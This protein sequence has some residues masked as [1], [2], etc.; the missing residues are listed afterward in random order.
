MKRFC[1]SLALLCAFAAAF[2]GQLCTIDP[3]RPGASTGLYVVG[4]KLLDVAGDEFRIRGFNRVHHDQNTAGMGHM[5]ANAVR[6][7]IDFA[8]PP[9]SSWA[10]V[11]SIAVANGLMPIVGNWTGTCKSDPAVLVTI[12]DAWVAQAPTWTKLNDIGV[13]NIANEFG[14]GNSTIWRDAYL[15]AITRM[16]AAGY[17]G[18]L[19][20]DAG[21][22][23]QDA[24]DIV[25]YGP[26]LLAADPLH[27]VMFDVHVYGGFHYPATATWMQD[28]AKSMAAFKASGL[29]II[30]G[31]FGPLNVGPS[32]TQVPLDTLIADAESN[33]FGWLAWAAD[34]GGCPGS[35]TA[36]Y[37]GFNLTRT[38]WD[39]EARGDGN[40][41][42]WGVAVVAKL[43]GLTGRP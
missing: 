30:L 32:Q 34:D 10:E 6:I 22:C 14:P 21:G 18:A 35:Y 8:K 13:V 7:S 33:G 26:A 17:T 42:P 28:Y 24:Q 2:A 25:L 19:M 1:T 5:G 3:P 39:K 4:P 15:T 36:S 16:R 9:A 12:V 38:C 23:G 43:R 11:Q 20:I 27:N 41:S 40:L 29:P 31:E 37:F